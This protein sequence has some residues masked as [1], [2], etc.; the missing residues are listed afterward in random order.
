M[1]WT[2]ITEDNMDEVY[3]KDGNRL[4]IACKFLDD[5]MYRMNADMSPTISTMAKRGGYYY[6][7]LPE[8]TNESK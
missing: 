1:Q 5:T 6:I 3:N 4:V 2:E 7:E 8:L